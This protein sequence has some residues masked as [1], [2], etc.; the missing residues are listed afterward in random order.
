MSLRRTV[1][2]LGTVS[3]LGFAPLHAGMAQQAD[4]AG[5]A[6]GA[7]EEIIV[8]A[9]RKEERAQT[10]PQAITALDRKSTRLN[11]SHDELSRMPSS[12]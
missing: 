7:P 2:L 6:V 12:A 1:V 5:A 4:Q 10:V 8:T 3:T 11:S 9:N